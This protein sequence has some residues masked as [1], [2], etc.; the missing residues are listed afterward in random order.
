MEVAA[1]NAFKSKYPMNLDH[2]SMIIMFS[3]F[4]CKRGQYNLSTY[5]RLRI[6]HKST[7]TVHYSPLLF[8]SAKSLLQRCDMGSSSEDKSDPKESEVAAA[9]KENAKKSKKNKSEDEAEAM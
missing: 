6:L 1:F 4:S 2:C 3:K 7:N 5:H 8:F 9:P